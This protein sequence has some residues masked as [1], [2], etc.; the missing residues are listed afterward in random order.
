M[1]QIKGRPAPEFNLHSALRA[2]AKCSRQYVNQ[3]SNKSYLLKFLPLL[4]IKLS[5]STIM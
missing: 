2:N 1:K 4:V 3:F 5:K